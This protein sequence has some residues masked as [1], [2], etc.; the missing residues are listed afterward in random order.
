MSDAGSLSGHQQHGLSVPTDFA[1]VIWEKFETLN[2]KSPR[3]AIAE[4]ECSWF[5]GLMPIG[6]SNARILPG[7]GPAIFT[8]QG[9]ETVEWVGFGNIGDTSYGIVLQSDG[10]V[11]KFDT[12]TGARFQIM[13]AGTIL[14][15]TSIFGFSQWGSQYLIFAKDQSNGYWLWDG[16]N[17]FTAGTLGPEV[18]LT[19]AGS[20][21]SSPPT[22]TVQQTGSGSGMTA[23]A[24]IDTNGSVSHVT[25]TAPGTGFA[26]GD[27]VA[28]NFTGGGSDD[29]AKASAVSPTTTTGGVSQIFVSNG[30]QQY[31]ARA[32]VVF[33]GG[34]GS[35]AIAS[36]SIQNG[37]VTAIAIV[38]P[39]SGY[40]SPPTLVVSDPGIP[41]SPG[42]PGGTGFSGF[43]NIAFGQITSV[44]I[45][46]GG[47]GYNQPPTV[48]FIGDGTNAAGIAQI[49]GGAV[50][51]V[52]MSNFGSGYTKAIMLFEGG[53]NAA[54]ADPTLMPFGISGTA[55]EVFSQRVWVTN[56]GAVANFPP[57]NR[58]IFSSPNSPVDF[59]NG[60]G[61]F[62]STDSFLRVG[63][64]WLKQ[65][66]GFLYLGGDSSVNY[67]SGVQTT[68]TGGT[69][70]TTFGNL[71][72]DP[73]YGSP[74]PSSVQ[75]FGRN[76]VFANSIGVF[77]SYGGAVTKASLPLDGFYNSDPQIQALTANFSSAVAQIFGIPV[78]M[79]LL[80][81][82]DQFTGNSVN[83]LLMYDGKRWWTSQQDLFL[84]YIATQEINS[85]LVAW[86]TDQT[87]VFR[88]FQR[89]TTAFQK[90][91]QSKLFSDPGYYTTKTAQ[92]LSGVFRVYTIDQPVTIT[93]DNEA[94]AGTANASV[95]IAP[96]YLASIIN[97]GGA[98][99]VVIN[100]H[101][102]PVSV[103]GTGIV[104]FG[105]I[106]V[107]QQ[108]RM[109][110]MTMVTS[111]SDMA[112]LSL[113]AANQAPFTVNV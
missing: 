57:R 113:M 30:G 22:V 54:N 93:I 62:Q 95:S 66:N 75:V 70:I 32:N 59:S 19:N 18:M 60:G 64:H 81:V 53:N 73:Q 108:G 23:T 31:T 39:G 112:L 67:V 91:I 35:G 110:G 8:T 58:T 56:G 2:T 94:G 28:L 77:V 41:G 76:I 21:Y 42:V 111:A 40:T 63:Y 107:G 6:P 38:N 15:P 45:A 11:H 68:G 84:A 14:S 102:D 4:G 24:Q 55:V 1:P 34:G 97:A 99:V 100:A 27:F 82:V 72:V 101:G 109:I 51:G 89:P 86:G 87:H 13:G 20:N 26:V 103:N 65:T 90:V 83:K 85:V 80:P 3:P 71:N 9:G 92:S 106:V 96:S 17:L 74:W 50:T 29:Q 47:T 16:T 105:P 36:L 79:L 69:A 88:L 33:S 52:L 61:A 25:I 98:A 43:C 48:R 37:T 10:A 44:G 78:Y 7:T 104:V 46:S 49:S 12:A 5:D